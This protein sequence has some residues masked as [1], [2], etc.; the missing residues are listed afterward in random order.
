MT[1]ALPRWPVAVVLGLALA[2]AAPA[3]PAPSGAPDK[4]AE[5]PAEKINKALDQTGDFT[6]EGT[7][8]PEALEKLAEQAKVNIVVDRFT[9]LNQLGIDLVNMPGNLPPVNLKLTGVK[10]RTAL[11]SV[12]SQYN[13][14]YAVVGDMVLV[15]TEDMATHRQLKQ[16]VSLDLDKVPA[17]TALKQLARDTGTN[18][19][20]DARVGKEAQ[21]PVTLQVDD[22][23]LDTSVKLVAEMAGLKTVR[24]GNVLF[25]TTKAIAQEM[26][27]DPD[28]QGGQ[29]VGPLSEQQLE[30]QL[31]QRELRMLLQQVQPQ[32]VPVPPPLPKD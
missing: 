29:P 20:L 1:L 30:M 17:A 18:V 12:L 8:L 27:Q 10:T 15:T 26:R 9:L 7:P 24:I 23:P 6:L 14:S 19:L 5:T 11:R 28:L 21:A 25:V 2:A 31:Q 22:V 3:A 32:V 4:K 13:L 16:R